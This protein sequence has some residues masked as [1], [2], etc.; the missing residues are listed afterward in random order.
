MGVFNLYS[1][2]ISQQGDSVSDQGE[3]IKVVL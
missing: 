2:E 1:L 3:S